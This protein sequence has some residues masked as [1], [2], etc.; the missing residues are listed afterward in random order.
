[1]DVF[2]TTSE[3]GRKPT[4]LMFVQSRPQATR[5]TARGE[6][7]ARHRFD[8]GDEAVKWGG[9][10]LLKLWRPMSAKHEQPEDPVP[11]TGQNTEHELFGSSSGSPRHR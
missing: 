3:T 1:V 10:A 4:G 2:V 9:P 11:L 7:M 8:E 6:T 5:L